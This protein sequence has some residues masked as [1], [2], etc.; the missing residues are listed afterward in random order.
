MK[1]SPFPLYLSSGQS[2]S[3]SKLDNPLAAF[4]GSLV[5]VAIH[6][7]ALG[8]KSDPAVLAYDESSTWQL[9]ETAPSSSVASASSVLFSKQDFSNLDATASTGT[10]LST[11][12]TILPN[13][14]RSF[15]LSNSPS[16]SFGL[17]AT[18]L[19]LNFGP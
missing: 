1:S 13:S 5:L 18:L 9:V 8:A 14:N 11:N 7:Y 12:T 16:D 19:V 15:G 2:A 6:F 3:A 4:L 10:I 17:E